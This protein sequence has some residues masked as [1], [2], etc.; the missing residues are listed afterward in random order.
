[1][2]SSCSSWSFPVCLI[3]CQMRSS[4]SGEM[5]PN[6]SS[7]FCFYILASF[8]V[9]RRAF[10]SSSASSLCM[11]TALIRSDNFRL[12]LIKRLSNTWVRSTIMSFLASVGSVICNYAI[13]ISIWLSILILSMWI[14]LSISLLSVISRFSSTWSLI[15]YSV[16]SICCI[17]LGVF[18]TSAKVVSKTLSSMSKNRRASCWESLPI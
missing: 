15:S 4:Y 8:Y 16:F 12:Y 18:F 14:F 13:L 17:N 9:A 5:L 6:W 2:A 10:T 1:M 7:S 11:T 3:P